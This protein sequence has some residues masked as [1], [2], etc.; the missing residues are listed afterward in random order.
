[1]A[2]LTETLTKYGTFSGYK[3]Y[4]D[5]SSALPIGMSAGDAAAVRATHNIPLA[6]GHIKYLEIHLPDD[7]VNLYRLNYTPLLK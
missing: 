6:Q 3:A 5:K 4:L 7:P 1:M 2:A